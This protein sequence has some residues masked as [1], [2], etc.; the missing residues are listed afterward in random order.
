M[1][2][3]Y[4]HVKTITDAS[5]SGKIALFRLDGRFKTMRLFDKYIMPV[6][7]DRL[8]T[9]IKNHPDSLIGIYHAKGELTAEDIRRYVVED[10]DWAELT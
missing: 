2:D 1:T 5:A 10:T 7:N 9:I 4:S 3:M 8:E 6:N